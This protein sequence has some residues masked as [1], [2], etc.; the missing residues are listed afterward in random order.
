MNYLEDDVEDGAAAVYG[1][2]YAR[3]REIKTKYDPGNVFHVNVNIKP[4]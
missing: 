1:S 4:A 3:L 2:N